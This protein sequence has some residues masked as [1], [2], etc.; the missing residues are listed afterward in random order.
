VRSRH[1]LYERHYLASAKSNRLAFQAPLKHRRK[2]LLD[3]LAA[4]ARAR[5]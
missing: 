2:E 4:D 5:S 3:Q 1:D